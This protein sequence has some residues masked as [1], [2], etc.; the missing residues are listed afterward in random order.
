ML[1]IKYT[2]TDLRLLKGILN[3]DITALSYHKYMALTNGK[4]KISF[5]DYFYLLKYCANSRKAA[6]QTK[7]FNNTLKRNL[8]NH[9]ATLEDHMKNHNSINNAAVFNS[10]I[11]SMFPTLNNFKNDDVKKRKNEFLADSKLIYSTLNA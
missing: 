2:N 10:P 5:Q 8:L 7:P 4:S 11:L 3:N 1:T 9:I 6:L